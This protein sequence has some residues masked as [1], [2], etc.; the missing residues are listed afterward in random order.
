MHFSVKIQTQNCSGL[1]KFRAGIVK[2]TWLG[3]DCQG[4][5]SLAR[6]RGAAYSI[7]CQT[8]ADLSVKL[9]A[10]T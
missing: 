3:E 8:A 6:L 10:S 5:L 1:K 9:P 2:N 4:S 7:C